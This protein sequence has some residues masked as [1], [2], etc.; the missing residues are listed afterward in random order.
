MVA[1]PAITG[2]ALDRMFWLEFPL[3][4]DVKLTVIKVATPFKVNARDVPAPAVKGAFK[5]Q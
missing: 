2:G 1:G 3:G 5:D 4:G